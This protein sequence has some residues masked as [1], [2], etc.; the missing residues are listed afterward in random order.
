MGTLVIAGRLDSAQRSNP[1][2]RS[3]FTS[4]PHR[5]ALHQRRP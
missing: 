1:R 2:R 4:R 3:T 5:A